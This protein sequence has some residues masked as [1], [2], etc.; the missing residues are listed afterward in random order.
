MLAA[1]LGETDVTHEEIIDWEVMDLAHRLCP[2]LVQAASRGN[3][4]GAGA[5][6]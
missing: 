5:P 3:D 4:T 2:G 6:A 1:G